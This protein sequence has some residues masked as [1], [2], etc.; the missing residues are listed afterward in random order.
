VLPGNGEL[1]F[2]PASPAVTVYSANFIQL[3][4]YNVSIFPTGTG[5]VTPTP[6]PLA[7]PPASGLF[8]VARQQVTLTSTPNAGQNFY[9]LINSPFWLPGGLSANPKTFYVMDDGTQIN[10][11]ALFTSSPVYTVGTNPSASNSYVFVD[12]GFWYAPK[13]FALPYDSSWTA[14][15]SHNLNID[16]IEQPFSI[17]S[18]YRFSNWSDAGA[19]NHNVTL[20]ASST[21]YTANVTG[22]FVAAD[23]PLE[24]CGG[25]IGLTPPSPT[26]DGFYPTGQLVTFSQTPNTGWTFTG[27]LYDLT[28]T[29]NPQSLTVS[30]EVLAA[31]DYNTASA[32]LSIS[33]LT[34]AAAVAGGGNF[35][36]AINGAGFTS[37]TLVFVN[38]VF[39]T[40]TL[41]NSNTLNVAMTT[42]D[43]TTPGAF[44]I[45]IENFPSGALCAA[46][47]SRPFF[48][49]NHPIVTPTPLS[50]AF[51]AQI[52][53]TTSAAKSV[54]VKNNSLSAVSISSISASGNFAQTNNCPASLNAAASCKV[55]ITFTPT[56]AGA[57]VGSVTI[58]D[59]APDSP[60][61]I[62]L[63][64]TG[65]TPLT[66]APPSLAFGTVPVGNTSP[67]K[68]VT[69]TNNQATAL[70][71][72]FA[73]SGN[74]TAVGSG[75]TPC[76]TSL[77]SKA[78]CTMSVTFK[79]TANGA[80]SG[81]VTVTHNAAF[82]PQEVALSGTGAGGTTA[83][84]T[85]NPTTASF[86]NQL[87]GTTS[88]AKVVTVKNV[89]ATTLNIFGILGSGNYT[90]LGAG[91][92][93][94]VGNL[95]AG[96]SCT[97]SVTFSPSVAGKI[98][99]SVTITD[100]APISVQI[101]NVQGTAVLPVSFTPASLTF[102]GQIVGTTSAS[103]TVTLFNNQTI[104]LSINSIGGSGDFTAVPG[105]TTPCGI[106]VAA[107]N[108]CTFTVT[109]TPSAVGTIKGAATVSHNAANSP[110]VVTLTGTGQ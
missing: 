19:Q 85:F 34:P 50:V 29:G 87:V 2:P 6:A 92:T 91:A 57:I 79:P 75:A 102:A 31:A 42:A 72:S 71:F 70:T 59:T 99:G 37:S 86:S 93:P 52:V 25:T 96:A 109:F 61:V 47:A 60:Q 49:A 54:T 40:A 5:T 84:L 65:A 106:T 94:C 101:F 28:G 9:E 41:V 89:S 15:S 77:A 27:W 45:F 98:V 83:P 17:N 24:S 32:P 76:G 67:G 30:D 46:V 48:V 66:I 56:T 53:G 103:Q 8:F 80:I 81:A 78:K 107:K 22:E 58:N 1:A 73:A 44:Q 36:L 12:S 51:P 21:A 100:T 35:T 23:Y 95:A 13:S 55:N 62:A 90:A 4:S 110:Q 14:G 82:S 20:P 97:M 88:P 105:G 10:T 39:R 26:G 33:S 68:T 43:I 63:T 69:L 11:A 38:G 16:T 64:G 74:Y 3:V 108:K 104:P 7:Y 18:R